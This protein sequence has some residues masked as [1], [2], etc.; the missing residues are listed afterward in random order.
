[1]DGRRL[2]D[3]RIAIEH[4]D[5]RIADLIAGRM[6]IVVEIA[7][8]KSEMRLPIRDFRVE[9][10]V[11]DRMEAR[12]TQLGL[13]PTLGRLLARLLIQSA[14]RIQEGIV[15]RVHSG[16]LMKILILGGGG[17]MGRWFCNYLDS[18]GHQVSVY[19]P[20]GPVEGYGFVKDLGGALQDSEMILL[21]TPLG[22][23]GAV[24]EEIISMKPRGI[25]FDICSLKSH[26]IGHARR[27]VRE[28]LSLTSL[29]PMFGPGV[30]TLM[31]RN[32]ILCRCGCPDAD[33]KVRALF[34]GT[35]ANLI[36]M[37]IEEHDELMAYVLGM[38]HAVNLIFTDMLV[39][40]GKSFSDLSR[41]A[42]STFMKQVKASRDVAYEAAD[43]YFEI[44]TLNTHTNGAFSLFL[45]VA[46]ELERAVREKD[47]EAF[48]ELMDRGRRYYGNRQG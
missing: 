17:R 12:C 31:E 20:Q 1:M 23:S 19:D 26:L 41:V 35:E 46:T 39:R 9:R 34:E 37:D 30:R 11:T 18:M 27:A 45:E 29:H 32:V 5:R 16:T 10:E 47:F 48:L 22:S 33:R 14:V 7:R 4:I 25:V 8:A 21:S 43:L 24:L 6:E 36:E 40:S 38:S 44:Q 2:E 3:L 15:E 28:G 13:D 42:S